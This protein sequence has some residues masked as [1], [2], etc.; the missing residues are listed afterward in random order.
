MMDAPTMT[1]SRPYMVRAVYQWLLDNDCTPYLLVDATTPGVDV[2]R[3][4]VND[5]R[6]VLNLAP[7]A[8]SGLDMGN[9][10]IVFLTRFSGTSMRV[11]VPV[12]AVRAIYA[13]E[14]GQG[15]AFAAEDEAAQ[16]AA[17]VPA[18]EEAVKAVDDDGPDDRPPDGGA[19]PGGRGGGPH[20]RVVK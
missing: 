13:Q 7:Q 15:L 12:T 10:D 20:L 16:A 2:P 19:S 1:S 11:S 8:V 17:P 5:G 14:N 9:A 18:P 6:V 3:Q 4:A